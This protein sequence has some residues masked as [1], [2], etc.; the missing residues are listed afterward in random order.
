VQ[1]PIQA[2]TYDRIPVHYDRNDQQVIR[3]PAAA[4]WFRENGTRTNVIGRKEIAKRWTFGRQ[5]SGKVLKIASGDDLA[6][7]SYRRREKRKRRFAASWRLHR[8]TAAG[9]SRRRGRESNVNRKGQELAVLRNFD[10][11]EGGKGHPRGPRASTTG[12]EHTLEE[13]GSRS[14]LHAKRIRQIEAKGA[15]KVLRHPSRVAEVEGVFGG[16]RRER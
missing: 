15:G 12:S 6:R 5:E 10:P 11:R 14:R 7:K 3:N 1:L 13:V 9:Y 16:V 4:S 8:R 2:S